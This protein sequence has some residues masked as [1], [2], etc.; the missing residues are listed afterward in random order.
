M[1]KQYIEPEMVIENFNDNIV[2][3]GEFD[4]GF[5]SVDHNAIIDDE[6]DM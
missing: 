4:F 5:G 1:K 3:G 2:C 6:E